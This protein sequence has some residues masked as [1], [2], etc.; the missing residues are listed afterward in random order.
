MR[1]FPYPEIPGLLH[2]PEGLAWDRMD[3][4]Y[5]NRFINEPLLVY[6]HNP[7]E[8]PSKRLRDLKHN[9]LG[10]VLWHGERLSE[11]LSYFRF[12]PKK[13]LASAMHYGRFSLHARRG[14]SRQ[15]QDLP[16]LAARAL[17]LA[18]LPAAVLVWI[19]DRLRL[20]Q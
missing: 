11:D 7:A 6:H 15:W 20:K 13:F 18:C 3:R 12:A 4:L 8:S 19:K 10:Y 16:G 2:I 14:P 9:A 5:L 1:R 17:W